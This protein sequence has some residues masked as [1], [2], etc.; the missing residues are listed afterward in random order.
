MGGYYITSDVSEAMSR[1]MQDRAARSL[2]DGI[3][4]DRFSIIVYGSRFCYERGSPAKY[5]HKYLKKYL[6]DEMGLEYLYDAV[7]SLG[8]N[9]K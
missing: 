7:P 9:E 2:Y 6:R 8:K 4:W 1:K 3:N 5:A